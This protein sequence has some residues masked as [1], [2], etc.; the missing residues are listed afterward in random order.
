MPS[1]VAGVVSGGEWA[2]LDDL[3]RLYDAIEGDGQSLDA[4]L[5]RLYPESATLAAEERRRLQERLAADFAEAK[6]LV[7]LGP[8]AWNAGTL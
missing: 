3:L 2:R 6:T 8:D 1:G 4:A 7:E 5:A